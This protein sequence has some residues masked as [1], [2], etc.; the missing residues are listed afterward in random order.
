MKKITT[1]YL[2]I[3]ILKKINERTKER[4]KMSEIL[5][6]LLYDYSESL[7]AN[8]D[9][10]ILQMRIDQLQNKIDILNNDLDHLNAKMAGYMQSIAIM[11]ANEEK[12]KIEAAEE[13]KRLEDLVKRCVLCNEYLDDLNRVTKSRD[14]R[15]AHNTCFLGLNKVKR[16]EL[17]G[18]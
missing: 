17:F 3:E 16:L 9:K 2:D 14:G 1:V 11:T 13:I 5:N 12:A 4:P 10:K 18:I 8:T 6:K 7:D 15:F